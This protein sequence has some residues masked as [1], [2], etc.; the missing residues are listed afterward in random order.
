MKFENR[1]TRHWHFV[2]KFVS[3]LLKFIWSMNDRSKLLTIHKWICEERKNESGVCRACFSSINSL[4]NGNTT[5]FSI[6]F[7]KYDD[8]HQTKTH[9]CIICRIS[10]LLLLFSFLFCFQVTTNPL[11]VFSFNDSLFFLPSTTNYIPSSLFYVHRNVYCILIT[12]DN[13]HSLGA[14]TV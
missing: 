6:S 12:H 1:K 2:K 4:R 10:F 11:Y 9:R 13:D 7:C 3:Y 5:A 8:W 14:M